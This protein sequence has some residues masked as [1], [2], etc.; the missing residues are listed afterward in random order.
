M[1]DRT[2][3]GG[4]TL[5]RSGSPVFLICQV[6]SPSFPMFHLPS[7]GL[8]PDR[9]GGM[10]AHRSI[11]GTGWVVGGQPDSP[12]TGYV[13]PVLSAQASTARCAKVF[14][15]PEPGLAPDFW[16]C[17]QLGVKL[18]ARCERCRHCLQSGVCSEAHA[19]HTLKEQAELA[20]IKANTR[21]EN[22]QIWCDYPFIKDPACLP[23]NRGAAIAVAEKVRRG[24]IKYNL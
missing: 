9:V 20:L 11:F 19:G 23:N 18:P 22:G 10:K 3:Y 7:G 17:D 2:G 1:A 8:G 13:A 6:C 5:T 24:L 15:T 12:S 4:T 16:E 21:L 14:V